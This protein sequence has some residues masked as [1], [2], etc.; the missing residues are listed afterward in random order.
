MRGLKQVGIKSSQT[1]TPDPFA[2]NRVYNL[3]H[4]TIEVYLLFFS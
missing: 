4:D 1:F 2:R 3:M